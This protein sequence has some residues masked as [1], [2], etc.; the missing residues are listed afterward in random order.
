[1]TFPRV[2]QFRHRNER[3]NPMRLT[4]AVPLLLASL[5]LPACTG[6]AVGVN[7][8]HTSFEQTCAEQSALAAQG[9]M[10]GRDITITCP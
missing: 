6:G 5:A 9:R 3:E 10:D 4:F 8:P 7:D 2:H 1:M